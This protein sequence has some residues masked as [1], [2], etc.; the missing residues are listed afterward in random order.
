MFFSKQ[1]TQWYTAHKRDLPWRN[2][3]EA[4][5]IWLSEI[6]LQQT[7]V[8]QGLPYFLKFL[9][10]FPKVENLAEATEEKVLKLWQGL[11]YYSRARNL[12]ATAK[13]I[14]ENLNGEF[15]N[16]KDGLLQLK[17][18]GDYTSSAIASFAFNEATP[19]VDGN[20]NRVLSRYF[21]I[22]LPVNESAGQNLIKEKAIEVLDKKNP[23]LHNQAIMEFG[24][25]QCKPKNPYC[26]ICPLQ[27]KCVAYQQGMVERLP[28]KI[29]KTKVQTRF[30]NYFVLI[31]PNQNTIVQQRKGKGIWENLFEF[32]VAEFSKKPKLIEVEKEMRS[33]FP[34][35]ISSTEKANLK[36][37]IH[38]L[39]HRKLIADFYIL[40]IQSLQKNTFQKNQKLLNL[41]ELETVPVPVLMANFIKEYLL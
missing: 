26:H 39:S 28:L 10:H 41:S 1:I 40:K 21:G 32:P 33:I 13:Y 4:Y 35:E 6:M 31:D 30:L 2:T 24:A 15:P 27:S 17:G 7:R 34:I 8:D 9:E 18:V 12:H 5:P 25:L 14:T 3:K 16:T 11:G 29:K 20:V 37:V 19:V 22:D 36:P 38:L 23:A